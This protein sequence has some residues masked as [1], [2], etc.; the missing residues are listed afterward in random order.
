M[1]YYRGT[2][3]TALLRD[4]AIR[5]IQHAS[6]TLARRYFAG[7]TKDARLVAALCESIP[8]QG[9]ADPLLLGVSD[10][11]HEVYVGDG[12]HRAVALMTVRAPRFPF[13]WYWIR[14][15]GVQI[16]TNPFPY[17]LLGL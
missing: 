12:H 1:G 10:R 13:R 3:P 14:D 15:F 17:H 6:W 4:D 16:E 9:L 11:T 2:M 7:R 8:E 5:P